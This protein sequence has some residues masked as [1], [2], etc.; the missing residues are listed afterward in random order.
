MSVRVR[1]HECKEALL[2]WETGQRHAQLTGHVWQPGYYC[3]LCDATFPRFTD[4]NA[5]ILTRGLHASVSGRTGSSQPATASVVGAV[6]R[7]PLSEVLTCGRCREQFRDAQTLAS[8]SCATFYHPK[9]S[10]RVM[11]PRSTASRD[12]PSSHHSAGAKSVH[13]CASFLL[14]L[15]DRI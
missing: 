4:C 3:S 8:V 15:N 10:F 14:E 7:T 13:V 9:R 1:C 2:G 12:R 5:H 11:C 6:T